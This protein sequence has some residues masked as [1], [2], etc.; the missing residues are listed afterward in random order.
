MNKL[1]LLA[2]VVVAA[3]QADNRN[4]DRKLEEMSKDLKD[5]KQQIARGGAGAQAPR[6]AR[7]EPDLA[8]T[9]AV[10]IAG[11]PA[12]GPADAKVTIVKA[13]DYAC[14]FC[15]RVRGTMDDLRKKYGN[16]LRFVFKQMV[17]HPQLATVS[18]FTSCAAYKQGKFLQMDQLLWEKGFK[19]RQFDKD[20][21]GEGGGQAQHCWETPA[22]CSIALG[23][24]QELGLNIDK[25]KAD[26]KGECQAMVQK[27]QREMQSFGVNGTPAFFINGRFLSGAQPIDKFITL[28][29]EELKKA[30]ERIQAGTPAASYYQQ[31]VLDKGLKQLE[32]PAQ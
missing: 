23:F 15:E 9:Y 16:D 28:I 17:V 24:A 20:P 14:P 10:Q 2:V 6:P 12:D 4:I 18:A 25:F 30:N 13:F 27:D 8:K 21:T 19:V 22:G 5:I 31:Y 7:V 3:C 26:M 1:V 11:D 32:R 29:D